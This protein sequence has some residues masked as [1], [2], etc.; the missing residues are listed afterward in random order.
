MIILIS[1]AKSLDF[2]TQV[3]T[4]NATT[5]MFLK[6]AA[7]LM[8]T[9]RTQSA[10]DLSRLMKLSESL[11]QLNFERNQRWKKK[12]D[13]PE[14]KPAV[15]AFQGDVYK[16]LEVDSFSAAELR[17]CQKH[18]RIL[19]GLYGV[20]RPMDLLQPYRLEMGTRLA[21][22]GG[23]NL[24]EFWGDTVTETLNQE[25]T[26]LKSKLVVNLASNEYSKVAKLK[27][28]NA[29]VVSPAFR[30]W[31]NGEYKMISF[32]A[33]RARGLMTRYAITN[34]IKTAE[35]LN[36]FDLDGYSYSEQLSKP[37]EPVFTRKQAL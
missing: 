2:E 30:D 9:L 13:G 14:S 19:S 18:V 1:P 20:L 22:E 32:F 28:L 37:N 35:G 3:K 17:R 21:N 7:T 5:P 34:S 16:G 27:N 25:L 36:D 33:K 29:N 10:E 12:H 26:A 4:K 15:F 11:G 24:Y 23:S 6:Q 8:K 31:K